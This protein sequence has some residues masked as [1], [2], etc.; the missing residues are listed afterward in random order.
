MRNATRDELDEQSSSELIITNEV[1][2]E[3][4]VEDQAYLV[5][6]PMRLVRNE[7]SKEVDLEL[8]EA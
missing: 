8:P 1:T 2:N 3:S 5:N 7:H 6:D 4:L